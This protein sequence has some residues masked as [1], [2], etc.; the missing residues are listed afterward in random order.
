MSEHHDKVRLIDMLQAVERIQRSMENVSVEEFIA[1]EEKRDA[2]V[3]RLQVIGE[4][5]Y[6]VS[7]TFKEAHPEIDR[8][9]IQGLRHRIVHDYGAIDDPTIHRIVNEY[10]PPLGAQLRVLIGDPGRPKD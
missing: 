10:V 9:K 3:Y 1:D 4:A 8:F 2:V 6:K 5:A 7:T